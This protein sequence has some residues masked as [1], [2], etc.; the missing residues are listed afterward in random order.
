MIIFILVIISIILLLG[1]YRII[2]DMDKRI[3][4]LVTEMENK[5]TGR[6]F[7][8]RYFI[9]TKTCNA[10]YQSIAYQQ[11]AMI[12]NNYTLT[13]NNK[14]FWTKEEC[15]LYDDMDHISGCVFV[16]DE[17]D[18][19]KIT[20]FNLLMKLK[21]LLIN[22]D[23]ITIPPIIYE[24]KL[25]FN[26]VILCKRIAKQYDMFNEKLDNDYYSNNKNFENEVYNIA[27]CMELYGRNFNYDVFKLP[28][29]IKL[30]K[31]ILNNIWVENDIKCVTILEY[32]EK[33]FNLKQN[34]N[35]PITHIS[36]A[37]NELRYKLL[38]LDIQLAIHT[39]N[40][41]ND[42]DA[43]VFFDKHIFSKIDQ[44]FLKQLSRFN[45]NITDH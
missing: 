10:L 20:I 23:T 2:K 27:R 33:S 34:D 19:R 25:M 26:L 32:Y 29:M 9:N 12:H 40:V 4:V 43:G 21:T 7:L 42:S 11:Y 37:E 36:Q 18:A 41:V 16:E 24:H 35:S 31:A 8:H 5:Y 14:R 6:V 3:Y 22:I 13:I 30:I 38:I 28:I 39:Y 17:T 15:L 44:N 45:I 1:L